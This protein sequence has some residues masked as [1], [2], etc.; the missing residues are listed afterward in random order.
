MPR[1]FRDRAL[2][3]VD[4]ENLTGTGLPDSVAVQVARRNLQRAV[5]VADGDLVVVG[6]SHAAALA[7]ADGWGA[8]RYVW[9]SGR[10]GADLALL[11][12]LE[13]DVAER[14]DHV[15][16]ASG[17]GIFADAAA[18]LGRRGCDV[19]VVAREGGISWRLWTAVHDVRLL[20]PHD[21]VTASELGTAA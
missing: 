19:T 5:P 1:E 16:I 7:I 3:L 17:D 9:R 4:I 18:G 10:D 13:E 8:A 6:S 12:V 11:G 14:F 2:H 21:A 20:R 15:V